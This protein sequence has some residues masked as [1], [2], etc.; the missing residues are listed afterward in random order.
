MPLTSIDTMSW[1]AMIRFRAGGR[2][3][4]EDPVDA[5]RGEGLGDGLVGA[6]FL[7]ELDHPTGRLRM[8]HPPRHFRHLRVVG[9]PLT[10]MR[11]GCAGGWELEALFRVNLTAKT[12]IQLV[13]GASLS[14]RCW[15]T[16]LD[17]S[18]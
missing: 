10:P 7:A 17:W 8:A 1:S 18:A 15:R 2:W 14:P 6:A 12:K 13:G 3:R 16:V 4:V 9:L 11:T 5:L